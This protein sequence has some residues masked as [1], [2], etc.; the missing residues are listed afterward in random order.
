MGLLP[1]LL[2]NGWFISWNIPLRWMIWGYP[3]C[4]KPSI[5]Y[6]YLCSNHWEVAVANG[7]SGRLPFWMVLC[8]SD[9]DSAGSARRNTSKKIAVLQL[10]ILL[11]GVFVNTIHGESIGGLWPCVAK[12]FNTPSPILSSMGGNFEPSTYGCC[13][14]LFHKY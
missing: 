11:L 8:P 5:V 3:Y 6:H 9:S 10:C 13:M 4:R 12:F 14:T 1:W 7:S 2:P